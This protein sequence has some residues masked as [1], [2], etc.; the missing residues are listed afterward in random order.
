M[1]SLTV[2]WHVELTQGDC[3]PTRPRRAGRNGEAI[4]RTS[5]LLLILLL[6]FFIGYLII[7]TYLLWLFLI[8]VEGQAVGAPLPLS[9]FPLSGTAWASDIFGRTSEYCH[10]NSTHSNKWSTVV[11]VPLI[12][13]NEFT[14]LIYYTVIK[15]PLIH[16][17]EF[18]NLLL[19]A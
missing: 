5:S 1:H 18:T 11:W 3:P 2:I 10:L 8:S 14:A 7:F 17:Y 15:I 13:S 6:L 16:S 12:H 9:F 19:N 4:D